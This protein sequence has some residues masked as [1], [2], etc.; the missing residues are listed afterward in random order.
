VIPSAVIELPQA[1]DTAVRST[2]LLQRLYAR[3]FSAFA[4]MALGMAAVGIWGISAYTVSLRRGEVAIRR[5]LGAPDSTIVRMLMRAAA[6]SVV[7]GLLVGGAI[8]WALAQGLRST[9]PGLGAAGTAASLIAVCA[10][11]VVACGASYL[12]A[13]RALRI[14]PSEA[15]G[16]E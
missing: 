1:L 16:A 5:A 9:I 8:A 4:L 12:P 11:V 7:P 15:L 6:A 14:E 2:L 13:R 3:G 10:F